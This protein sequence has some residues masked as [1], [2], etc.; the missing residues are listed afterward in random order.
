[1]Q[2]RDFLTAAVMAA[3]LSPTSAQGLF[4]SGL[5]AHVSTE[6]DLASSPSTRPIPNPP[7]DAKVVFVGNSI[8][9]VTMGLRK[10]GGIVSRLDLSSGGTFVQELALPDMVKCFSVSF[11][12][13]SGR[14]AIATWE[15][16]SK[17]ATQVWDTCLYVVDANARLKI[18]S[19]TLLWSDRF[20]ADKS[21]RWV[22][23]G[24]VSGD[25][26]LARIEGDRNF[27]QITLKDGALKELPIASDLG[28]NIRA[29]FSPVINPL[30][31]GGGGDDSQGRR[32]TCRQDSSTRTVKCCGKERRP[33]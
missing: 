28:E 25:T 24:W 23:I 4:S 21:G 18:E 19:R 33:F 15:K 9:A 13:S 17:G 16:R 7:A 20:P 11:D 6:V 32:R 1:M 30:V 14:L 27:F 2:R 8:F 31:G 3:V 12:E 26:L 22:G 10:Q 29:V 5:Y